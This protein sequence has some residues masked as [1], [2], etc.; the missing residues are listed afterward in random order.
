MKRKSIFGLIAI[1][2]IVAVAIFAGCVEKE[3]PVSAPVSTPAA[4]TPVPKISTPIPTP[5][6]TP[7]PSAYILI[8]K[9]DSVLSHY[10]STEYDLRDADSGYDFLILNYTIKNHGYDSFKMYLSDFYIIVNNVKY[11]Y[12]A[13]TFSII[14]G[15]RSGVELLDGGSTSG[16]VVFEIPETKHVEYSWGYE[17]RY[18]NIKL[19]KAVPT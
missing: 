9:E 3:A 15:L 18:Y 14:G 17:T 10:I 8:T 11:D 1:G 6:P 16:K 7:T 19:K 2:A 12:D 13:S 4:S 5:T